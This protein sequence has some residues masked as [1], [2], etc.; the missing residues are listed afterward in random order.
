MKP[1]RAW[2]V[3]YDSTLHEA[4]RLTETE[5][6]TDITW[7]AGTGVPLFNGFGISV[8]GDGEVLELDDGDGRTKT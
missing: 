6:S 4:V 3:W 7:G 1:D 5:Q 2:Q 8:Y